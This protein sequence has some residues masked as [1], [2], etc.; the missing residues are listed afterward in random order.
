MVVGDGWLK[1]HDTM[2]DIGMSGCALFS[3]QDLTT[4]Q[5]GRAGSVYLLPAWLQSDLERARLLSP[6]TESTIQGGVDA[7]FALLLSDAGPIWPR[8]ASMAFDRYAAMDLPRRLYC[9]EIHED[10]AYTDPNRWRLVLDSDSFLQSD[11]ESVGRQIYVESLA[12]A[13]HFCGKICSD[14]D[15]GK[16]ADRFVGAIPWAKRAFLWYMHRLAYE[17]H[18]AVE[19]LQVSG[20]AGSI[21]GGLYGLQL[22][23]DGEGWRREG[24][25][26]RSCLNRLSYFFRGRGSNYTQYWSPDPALELPVDAVL[27]CT[28]TGTALLLKISVDG[29]VA[30][31]RSGVMQ[32]YDTVR[33]DVP[34]CWVVVLMIVLPA[35][36]A[37]AMP[38]RWSFETS[39]KLY[40]ETGKKIITQ[41]GVVR[42]ARIPQRCSVE[43]LHRHYMDPMA[44]VF[45]GVTGGGRNGWGFR[46]DMVL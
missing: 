16:T 23:E 42:D 3:T 31:D 24:N 13:L 45:S 30:L 44:M 20:H 14:I 4:A 36:V 34:A 12:A 2:V 15:V 5:T 26:E 28:M 46:T 35:H 41:V 21:V 22:P 29:Q 17:G 38:P 19:G 6:I 32:V 25:S 10:A 11:V 40:E 7:T 43:E 37:K 1:G 18:F 8:K 27:Y 39:L 33:A 9:T